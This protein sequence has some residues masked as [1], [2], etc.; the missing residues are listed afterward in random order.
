[1]IHIDR[2]GDFNGAKWFFDN[3]HSQN[4]PYDIIGLSYYPWWHGSLSN[5]ES[6]VNQLAALYKKPILI[7]ETAYPWTLNWNDNVTNIVGSSSQLLPGY[8]A[9]LIGQQ[10][11]LNQIFS[12]VRNIPYQLGIGVFYWEPDYISI[13]GV[14]S[15]WENLAMFDFQGNA[16][17]SMSAFEPSAG[18]PVE[19]PPPHLQTKL[20][21]N[22]PN[23]FNPATII[24]FHVS[25]ASHVR[26]TIYNELGQKIE[27]LVNSK[28]APGSYTRVFSSLNISSG[29]Y[30][31]K[32]TVGDHSYVRKMSVI[33]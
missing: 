13:P 23:P 31:Y 7:A 4:V 11:Y 33:K 29:I 9:T 15:P 17:A 3:L 21:Q 16:L 14:G 27:T 26:L 2:G 19:Q 25:N 5:M 1:M 6:N 28:L 30:F 22:Y 10:S 32:L 8:P 24:P 12:I 18:T 20:L